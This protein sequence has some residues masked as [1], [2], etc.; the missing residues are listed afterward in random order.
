M[1]IQQHKL[2]MD[3]MILRVRM[4][5]QVTNDLMMTYDT[6]TDTCVRLCHL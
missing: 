6:T 3:Q 4:K 2:Y 1:V 5:Q